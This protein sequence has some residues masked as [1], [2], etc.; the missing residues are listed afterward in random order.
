MPS[1][2]AKSRPT[3][4]LITFPNV[5]L[6]DIAGP[7][8]VFADA[9][10]CG[11]EDYEIVLVSADGREQLTDTGIPLGTEKMA[12]W[13]GRPIHTLLIAGGYG[14]YPAAENQSLV[15]GT[16]ALAEGSQRIGSV[17]T[18]ALILAATGLLNGRSAVTHWSSCRALADSHP[19]VRV[20]PDRIYTKDDNIWTSA[21]VTAGIDMAL[22]MVAEDCGRNTAVRLAR[23][24]V[25]FMVRPGGQA[26]FSSLLDSQIKDTAGRFDG[27]H[28]WIL[29]N[30]DQ[31]LRIGQLAKIAGM[32][33][34]N[35]ARVYQATT[36]RTPAKAVE[37][38]RIMAA[39]TLLEENL[40]AHQCNSAAN[41]LC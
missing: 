32:S 20:E 11:G 28:S 40:N 34:R 10:N 37:R 24:L 30:L 21:G 3:V 25:A 1:L 26:Q 33:E 22:A 4:V 17:C 35:F 12:D 6:L 23:T 31:D 19:D 27:L 5:K 14:A 7:L 36:G 9:K 2:S 15:A 13:I 38:F 18:G 39:R 41:R 16:L 29:D 8:Q